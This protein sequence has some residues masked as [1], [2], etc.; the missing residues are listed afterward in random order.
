MPPTTALCF[1]VSGFALVSMSRRAP[2]RH[3]PLVL[4]SGAAMVMALA[5]AMLV[6][7]AT[8]TTDL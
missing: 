1:T 7:Y 6:G 8:N 4:G 2:H 5:L 3:R